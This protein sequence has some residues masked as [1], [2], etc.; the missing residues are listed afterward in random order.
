M[1]DPNAFENDNPF[2]EE[3]K[4]QKPT[5][6]NVDEGSDDSFEGFGEVN[7]DDENLLKNEEKPNTMVKGIS[8]IKTDKSKN[9]LQAIIK[10]K[11]NSEKS[12]DPDSELNNS[13]NIDK[14]EKEIAP[15]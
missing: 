8:S 4:E 1:I 6:E 12:T 14:E 7:S 15:V 11:E 10:E 5:V 3:N 13:F 9:L 2:N